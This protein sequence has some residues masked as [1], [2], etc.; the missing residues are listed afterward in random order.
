[1]KMYFALAPPQRAELGGHVELILYP[2]GYAGLQLVEDGYA[3]LCALIGCEKLRSLGGWDR[4]LEHMQR[5]S[6]HLARRLAGARA[7]LGRPLALSRIPYGYCA[8]IP[9]TEEALWRLGDQAAVIPSFSGDGMAIAL[10][11]ADRAAQ[12]Y[13]EGATPAVFQ[14]EI[15]RQLAPRLELATLISRAVTAVPSLSQVVRFFPSVLS[16]IFMAT[17]IPRAEL[18]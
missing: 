3:N 8:P 17:R 15:R 9:A 11:T 6:V 2:G 7:M 14:A 16:G 10:Y 5:H 18:V 13:L 12:L 1:M 4:L